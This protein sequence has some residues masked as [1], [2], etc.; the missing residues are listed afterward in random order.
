[1]DASDLSLRLAYSPSS[2]TQKWKPIIDKNSEPHAGAH[3]FSEDKAL[4]VGV[5]AEERKLLA[6]YRRYPEASGSPLFTN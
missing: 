3:V 4:K 1:V 2:R 5:D 6:V